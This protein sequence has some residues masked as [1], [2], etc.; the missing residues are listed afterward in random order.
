M[1]AGRRLWPS[2]LAQRASG[3]RAWLAH[4]K[5]V[6][7]DA[8]PPGMGV[9]H[10]VLLGIWLKILCRSRRKPLSFGGVLPGLAS[11]N[12]VL[13]GAPMLDDSRASGLRELR[14]EQALLEQR[15]R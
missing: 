6:F 2:R 14:E 10:R 11:V 13:T 7:S 3:P 8:G 15:R 1:E 9:H 12:T 4:P 5:C